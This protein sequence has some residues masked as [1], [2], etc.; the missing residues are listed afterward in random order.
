M[1]DNWPRLRDSR[2]IPVSPWL[3][4]IA[5][6]VQ[7]FPDAPVETYYAIAQQHYLAALAITPEGRILLVRQYRPA[8]ERFSLELP[9]GLLDA[10]E[11]PAEAMVRELR[12]ETGYSTRSIQLMGKGATCASRI[13][14]SM[15]SF[16]IETGERAHDFVEEPGV[17]VSSMWPAELRSSILSGE[18][19]EQGH[20]GVVALAVCKGFLGI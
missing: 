9:A 7:F 12:E 1:V 5:R 8:I 18:F 6:D 16:F 11:E 14:N 13:D 10:G 3:E 17:A 15:Y 19:A 2:R 20:L 4:V